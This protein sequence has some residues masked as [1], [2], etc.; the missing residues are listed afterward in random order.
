MWEHGQS[1]IRV[2]DCFSVF[3]TFSTTFNEVSNG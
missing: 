2:T 1:I 3:M